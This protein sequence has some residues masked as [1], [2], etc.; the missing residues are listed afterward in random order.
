MAKASGFF[1]A[2][3]T[4]HVSI[5]EFRPLLSAFHRKRVAGTGQLA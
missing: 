4:V 3:D 2:S 1:P 5:F